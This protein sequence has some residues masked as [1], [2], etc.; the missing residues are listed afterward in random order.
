MRLLELRDSGSVLYVVSSG[1]PRMRLTRVRLA[2]DIVRVEFLGHLHRVVATV[3][4]SLLVG[5]DYTDL[6]TLIRSGAF[7]FN[8]VS[9]W[10]NV[11]VLG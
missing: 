1:G 4:A 9:N 10:L 6:V 7:L 3:A 11:G 8:H 2:S 5:V